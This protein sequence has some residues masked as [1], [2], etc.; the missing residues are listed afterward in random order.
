MIKKAFV[1]AIILLAS[2]ITVFLSLNS[3]QTNTDKVSDSTAL[4]TKNLEDG[5]ILA[6]KQCSSCHLLVEPEFLD[7]ETWLKHV[8]PAMA[9]KLGIAVYGEDQYVNNPNAKST[10][11]YDDWMKI[12]SFYTAISPQKLNQP[13]VS[14]NPIKDWAVFS[15]RK[16][17][18]TLEPIATTTM[19]AF[20]TIGSKI[21]TS[22]MSTSKLYQWSDNLNLQSTHQFSS[23]AVNAYFTKDTENKKHGIFTFIGSMDAID[24]DNGK[25]ADILLDHHINT[26]ARGLVGK[27]RRPVQTLSVDF[28]KD[29][30]NDLLVCN[31]G[32]NVGGLDLYR[33][34]P[35]YQFKKQVIREMP[36]ATHAVTGDFNN[37]GWQDI[38]C[39]FAQADEGIWLFLNN[40]KGGF[41]SKNLLRFLPL[42]GSSSFQLVDFNHDGKADI[43]YTCGDNSDYSRVLKPFHGVYIFINQGDFKYKKAYFYP[44]NG[45]TKAVA[46]DF[47]GN[48]RNDIA[49]IAFFPDLKNNP[50][51]GFTYLEQDKPMHF[52]PHNLPINKNGRW[53]CMDV[54]DYNKDGK[55]DIIL[56]NFSLGFINQDSVK[57]N[58]DTHT[59]FVILENISNKKIK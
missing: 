10:V 23:P 40:R 42:Y 16:P 25:T 45:A 3:C 15:L 48:G 26:S 11:T 44:V 35:G 20:D 55:L 38:I 56:G 58:W 52:L 33:Q 18:K 2:F 36:G 4:V 53:I 37:D 12:V 22:A 30:L 27:L 57:Q 59:P 28:D 50:A 43:L 31:F 24:V 29:G 32:H 1:P 34:T 21:F 39:L 54:K 49:V 19:V 51:E 17:V 5:K 41:T 14:T 47:K 8:L 6:Q 7:K 13:K 9:P 46:A